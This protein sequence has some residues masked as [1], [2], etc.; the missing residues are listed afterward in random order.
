MHYK[1][2]V[3]ITEMRW[4]KLKSYMVLYVILE[5]PLYNEIL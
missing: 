1:Y 3:N 4:G 2:E 5:G